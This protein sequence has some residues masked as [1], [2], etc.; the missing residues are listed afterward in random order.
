MLS[1][2]PM[3]YSP[4]KKSTAYASA[5]IVAAFVIM[6]ARLVVI[7]SKNAVNMLYSDEWDL[8]GAFRHASLRE[9]FFWQAGPHRQGLAFLVMKLVAQRSH[10]NTRAA[11]FL[12]LG[13]SLAG[14]LIATWLKKR[15]FGNFT[16]WD[17]II[18]L[19]FLAPIQYEIF[20]G[21]PNPSS[22]SFSLSMV[23]LCALAWTIPAPLVRWIA[24]L[25]ANF[26]GLYSGY[27]FFLGVVTPMLLFLEIFRELRARK[28]GCWPA[29]AA[30][31][32]ALA[33]LASF[34]IRYHFLPAA[35]CFRFPEHPLWKYPWFM[36]LMFANLF[37]L[38]G[39]GPAATLAGAALVIAAILLALRHVG[40]LASRYEGRAYDAVMVLLLGFSLLYAAAAAIGRVCFGVEYA[41]SSRYSLHLFPAL[42]AFYFALAAKAA[43]KGQR[44]LLTGYAAS[45]LIAATFLA[46]RDRRHIA[47]FRDVKQ[48]WKQCY[49]ASAD[50]ARCDREAALP[51][52]TASQAAQ[53][54]DT[55]AYMKRN[56]LNLFAEAP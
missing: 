1:A 23:M 29:V 43:G 27:G 11:A 36:S 49:V 8:Y 19:I 34:F 2:A 20:L 4:A 25:V 42:L 5:V 41:Q 45:L 15:L 31:M 21:S 35:E 30:L 38:K 7:I 24:V 17:A 44:Y 22:T 3:T 16:A 48:S 51:I 47:F 6:T 10:W 53:V 40:R 28:R 37:R 33:S 39:H 18:P 9:L 32:A 26:L 12:L 14:A 54:A 55:L 50:L 56:R 13:F 52:H 46:P